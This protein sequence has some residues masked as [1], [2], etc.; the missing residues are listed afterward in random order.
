MSGPGTLAFSPLVF[1]RDNHEGNINDTEEI[2]MAKT[3][4][5]Q[6]AEQQE[7]SLAGQISEAEEQLVLKNF[8][9]L[10]RRGEGEM[11]V[12]VRRAPDT[13]MVEITYVGVHEKADLTSL[14]DM[15]AKLRK[16]GS[17]F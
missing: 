8:A 17:R 14:R 7:N 3:E 4:T 15:Y 1:Q 11:R 6:V 13:G 10:K 9:E 2:E 16:K 5:D 12:A